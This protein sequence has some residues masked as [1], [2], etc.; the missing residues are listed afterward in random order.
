YTQESTGAYD[1]VL[2]GTTASTQYSVLTVNSTATLNGPLNLIFANGFVPATTNTFTIL[3]ASSI[4]GGFSSINSPAIPSGF[5]WSITYNGG[6]AVLSLIASSSLPQ[7]LTVTDVGTGSGTVTDDLEQISC[8]DTAGVVTGTCSANYSM[9]S[10]VNLT[11]TPSGSSTFAGWGGACSGTGACS[12]TMGSAQSVTASF[13]P[14]PTSIN[15]TFPISNTPQTQEAIFNCP[16]NTN[17]CTD[18]NAHAVAITIPAVSSQV[19]I[20]VLAT[21][22]PP[23]QADGICETGNNV[24]NDFDCRFVTFF[25][26]PAVSNGQKEPLCDPYANGNCVH[27][28]VFSGQAGTEPDPSSY[29]GPVSWKITWNN[30]SFTP[31][32]GYQTPPRLFDDPDAPVSDTSP[33][34]TSC[35]TPMLVGITNPQQETFSCQ[36][37]FD[38]TTFFDAAEQVDSG[39][40]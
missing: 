34:G 4:S 1:A 39:I 33:Y 38:V 9:N 20:T 11:A 29:T 10:I 13:M 6:H 27:Y 3:T 21:E 24:T 12:V 5:T 14:T 28:L 32:A 23:A 31:P 26:G 2:G 16:S 7:T 8:V 37:E 18:Q 17:P 15:L 36:F 40:G 22:V 30:E 25:P 35:T 19:N